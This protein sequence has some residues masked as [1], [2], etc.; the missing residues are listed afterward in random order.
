VRR[1]L[2]AAR[3]EDNVFIGPPLAQAS[4][5]Y[6][7]FAD[8][9]PVTDLV[10]APAALETLTTQGEGVRGDWIDAHY[11]KFLAIRDE[12]RDLHRADPAFEPAWPVLSN[13]VADPSFEGGNGHVV[14]EPRTLAVMRLFNS[15]YTLMTAMLVRCFAHADEPEAALKT[16][17][18][19]AVDLMEG[20]ISPLGTLLATMP[21]GIDS[22]FNAGASFEF[23]RA[24]PCCP[25]PL[26]LAGLSRA[27]DRAGCPRRAARRR[28]R[29]HFTAQGQRS[30]R[31]NR[32][33]TGTPP[34]RSASQPVTPQRPAAHD[35]AAARRVAWSTISRARWGPERATTSNCLPLNWLYEAKKCSISTSADS[36]RSSK[37][38][39]WAWL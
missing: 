36:R 1:A 37:H 24:I 39:T 23:Y 35:S 6:F 9:E 31:G 8:L 10:S 11:G 33:S 29:P 32:R 18:G 17:A 25:P 27:A 15:C 22:K 20:V 3:G 34:G 7:R 30:V 5:A 14:D 4:S 28:R 13:P 19:S 38:S 2:V 16:P 26:G 21:A 12:F